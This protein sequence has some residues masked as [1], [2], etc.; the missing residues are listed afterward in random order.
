MIVPQAQRIYSKDTFVHSPCRRK[1]GL[2]TIMHVAWDSAALSLPH[3]SRRS[4]KSENLIVYM[5]SHVGF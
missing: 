3:A 5:I 4:R 2:H 1:L